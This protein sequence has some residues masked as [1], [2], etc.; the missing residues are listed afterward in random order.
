M[1][2]SE[3]CVPGDR[4]CIADD[5]H[6]NGVGTF[7]VAGF[8]YSSLAG[9]R[10]DVLLPDG[11]IQVKVTSCSKTQGTVPEVGSLVTA[12]ILSMNPRFCKCSILSVD[13]IVLHEAFRGTIR[14]EDI[15]ATEKD[16]VEVYKS[17]R[18]GDIILAKVLM[19]G[20][21][22]MYL[23]TTAE[24][25]L[26]VVVATSE[27]GC[28][29]VPVSWCEM[30]CPETMIRESRKVAKAQPDFIQTASVTPNR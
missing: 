23:L 25:E 28:S 30:Q 20:E 17:F 16:K 4:L 2:N 11:K 27:A 26:G 29:M 12:R 10:Q 5:T 3:I 19:I 18:P 1:A 15:R 21:G 24:N 13:G 14:R 6:Q 9:F 7:T 8:I 22:L